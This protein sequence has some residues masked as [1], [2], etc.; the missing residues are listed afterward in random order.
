MSAN[1]K[2]TTFL[3]AG[4]LS[5]GSKEVKKVMVV[6]YKCP[7]CGA[8][9][10]FDSTTG[11]LRCGSC[12]RTDN[13]EKM[14]GGNNSSED[15]NTSYEMDEEDKKASNSAFEKDYED[16][17]DTDEPSNHST[18]AENE[19]LEYHCNNCGAVLITDAQ[20]TATTC[21]FCGAGVVLGDRLSGSLAPA[22]VIPFTINKEQAQEAFKKWCRKGLLTPKDFMNADRIKNI[23][24]LYVPFWLYDINGRGEAEASCTRVRVYPL[25]DWIYTETKFYQVYRKVDLNYMR[26]PCDA[27]QKMDDKLMDK[28]EPFQYGDLKDFNMPYLAGYI[29]EKYDF[30]DTKLLPRIK[31]RVAPYVDSYIRSTISGYSTVNFG[32]KDINLRQKRADYTLLPIWMVC[33]DY[34]QAEHTFAM[35]GQ[36]GKIV[37]KPPLSKAKIATWFMG[38]SVGTFIILNIIT[39]LLGGR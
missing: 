1:E 33:Y 36:T 31:D 37:G 3:F 23:T 2:V 28:L 5:K 8:D 17:S 24:G 38:I 32:R 14:A 12:G 4:I 27:S 30:D 20:T 6:Q 7:N 19:V 21:S 25:G 16:A 15:G 9:M 26:I 11:M 34:K 35:N 13:I 39:L 29:S 22:K 18:F 10:A